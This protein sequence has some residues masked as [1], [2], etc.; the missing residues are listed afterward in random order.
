MQLI[1]IYFSK[2]GLPPVI[3]EMVQV[4]LVTDQYFFSMFVKMQT[5]YVSSLVFW[6]IS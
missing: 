6:R 4:P 3:G 1:Q 5:Y 2:L